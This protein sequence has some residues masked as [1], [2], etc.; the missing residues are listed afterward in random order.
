MLHVPSMLNPWLQT[1]APA[2][3]VCGLLGAAADP[4]VGT[5]VADPEPEPGNPMVVGSITAGSVG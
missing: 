4:A 1:E 3:A 5:P 2:L